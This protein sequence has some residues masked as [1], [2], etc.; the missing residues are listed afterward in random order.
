M[1]HQPRQRTLGRR[2]GA[3]EQISNE[4]GSVL[5]LVTLLLIVFLGLVALAVDLGMLYV[6]RAE[7]QRTADAAAHAGAVHW[8]LNPTATDAEIAA[9]AIETGQLN[10]VRSG[11]A[12]ITEDD[13]EVLRA[14]D[15][16]RARAHRTDD[17]MNPVQTLFAGVLG[18]RDVNV[19]AVAAAEVATASHARCMLP[20]A[21]PDRWCEEGWNSNTGECDRWPDQMDTYDPVGDGDHYQ[22]WTG[23]ENAPPSTGWGDDNLGDT[24][25]LRPEG[26]SGGQ[27]QGEGSGGER[28]HPGWWN[29]FYYNGAGGWGPNVNDLGNVIQGCSSAP[30]L[31]PGTTINPAPGNMVPLVSDWNAL[32]NQDPTATWDEEQL[33]VTSGGTG[34]DGECR[35]SPR[36]RPIATFNPNLGP[37]AMAGGGPF[38]IHTLAGLFIDHVEGGPPGQ[39]GTGGGG[40]PGGGGGPGGGGPP[41]QGGG[42]GGGG[43]AANMQIRAIFVQ[44][45]GTLEGGGI[46]GEN[47]LTKMIR[48]VE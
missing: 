12:D 7:A 46:V 23:D 40:P 27:G 34:E 38:Q 18:F 10:L 25:Y 4:R 21:L 11:V 26:E 9:A 17:R 1:T 13:I 22:P 16:V 20:I 8:F 41:G 14:E 36:V 29:T 28:W 32:I 43:P 24:V 31:G 5:A 48:I 33:C 39:G 15:R 3:V 44:I 37:D 42:E 2:P 35:S 47:L 45:D 19:S 6:A 30:P